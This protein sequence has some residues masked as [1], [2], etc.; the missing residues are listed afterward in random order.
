MRGTIVIGRTRSGVSFAEWSGVT[1][2]TLG[3]GAANCK[4]RRR[5]PGEILDMKS[6]SGN[7]VLCLVR[8]GKT[9]YV[10]IFEDGTVQRHSV[11]P[12]V[13][14]AKAIEQGL[15]IVLFN[16]H[17]IR[18]VNDDLNFTDLEECRLQEMEGSEY[19]VHVPF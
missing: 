18:N 4:T 16:H 12:T 2:R 17:E 11:G 10:Y 6:S 8:K 14:D 5:W 3:D 7:H 19:L 13:E 1:F 15:L 9:M